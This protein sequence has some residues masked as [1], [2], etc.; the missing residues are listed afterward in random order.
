MFT[1]SF[2]PLSGYYSSYQSSQAAQ[3]RR[4]VFVPFRGITVLISK[5]YAHAADMWVFVP[6]RG[7]TVLINELRE[8]LKTYE[9]V[10]VPFRGITV[11]IQMEVHDVQT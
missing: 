10:F 11:L 8:E 2:R 7:I 4:R 6:F 1:V 9:T 3:S 5:E